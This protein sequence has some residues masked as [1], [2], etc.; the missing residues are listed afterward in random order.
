MNTLIDLLHEIK[1][2]FRKG[3]YLNEAS[4]RA[5]I[6]L[7]VLTKLGWSI[8]DPNQI[9]P[10]YPLKS[11]KRKKGPAPKVDLA[12]FNLSDTNAP[13][14]IIELKRPENTSG[15]EQIFEYAYH[16]GATTAVLTNG[17]SWRFYYLQPGGSYDDRLI[18]TLEI[19][20]HDLEE[21]AKALIRYLSFKN[22]QSGK[23]I[24]YAQRDQSQRKNQMRARDAIPHAWDKLVEGDADSRL[25]KI[26]IQVTSSI[27]GYAPQ[28]EDVMAFILSLRD[29]DA[30][31][32]IR[33]SQTPFARKSTTSNG[34]QKKRHTSFEKKER[35]AILG[36]DNETS[37]KSIDRSKSGKT[38]SFTFK[39]TRHEAKNQIDAYAKIIEL[40]ERENPGFLDRLAPELS[41]P[42]TKALAR[43]EHEL[44]SPEILEKQS[45]TI[46]II[47]GWWLYTKI[48]RETKIKNLKIACNVAGI[49]FGK[50]DGLMVD[51]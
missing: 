38:L 15:D 14:G 30:T 17:K 7:P 51:F 18:R 46:Q 32:F 16:T 27:S 41:F 37:R 31:A 2:N 33:P 29:R 40:M 42:K 26:L 12:L 47:D 49:A 35:R 48:G 25:A 21:M 39:G 9:I 22:F 6:V 45:V 24:E 36:E 44:A 28:D 23:A 13:Q 10:E 20:E 1:E 4:V 43:S 3:A 34:P 50:P 11:S 8:T 19:E 5:Q